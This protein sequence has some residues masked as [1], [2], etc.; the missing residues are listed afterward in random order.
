[1]D[2]TVYV[3]NQTISA[4]AI[5]YRFANVAANKDLYIV[6]NPSTTATSTVS[7][8]T[9]KSGLTASA[10]QVNNYFYL[11][12]HL[13]TLFIRHMLIKLATLLLSAAKV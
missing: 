7:L 8:N 3:S 5:S 6:Y 12:I 11:F 4:T 9:I 13:F 10:V 1:M 2:N